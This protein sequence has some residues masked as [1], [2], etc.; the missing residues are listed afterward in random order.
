MGH[1]QLRAPILGAQRTSALVLS[2]AGSLCAARDRATA[3]VVSPGVAPRASWALVA[4]CLSTIVCLP[5]AGQAIDV[6]REYAVKAGFLYHFS[7][8]V[9]W[10]ATSFASPSEPFVIGVYGTNPFGPILDKLAHKKKVD[11]R[12]IDVR[13]VNS[14]AEAQK[15]QIL[16]VPAAVPLQTQIRLLQA[17]VHSPVLVVGETDDFVEHGGNVQFFLEGNKV[18]F[19]FGADA[20]KRDDLKVSSKLLTLAKIIADH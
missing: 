7:N 16:F 8:Y 13:V 17:T 10:P 11:G 19:A 1:F 3:A 18:R 14:V 5:A 15:C 20:L 12:A 6:D 2:V 4:W 9:D